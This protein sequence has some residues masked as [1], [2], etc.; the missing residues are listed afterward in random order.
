MTSRKN[1][2]W[3]V[4][5]RLCF[6]NMTVD[7]AIWR[8]LAEWIARGTIWRHRYRHDKRHYILYMIKNWW[9]YFTRITSKQTK[10]ALNYHDAKITFFYFNISVS[11][12]LWNSVLCTCIIIVLLCSTVPPSSVKLAHFMIS[13]HLALWL[14]D[15]SL[16]HLQFDARRNNAKKFADVDHYPTMTV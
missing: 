3:C 16:F 14:A 6:I 2:H 9:Q 13:P 8:C 5:W 10:I 11:F 7:V 4:T 15:L 1:N 12:Y